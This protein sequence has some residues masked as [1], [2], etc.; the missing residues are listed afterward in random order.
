MKYLVRPLEDNYVCDSIF[1][2]NSLSDAMM[3][4]QRQYL[5]RDIKCVIITQP[6]NV[7]Y[8]SLPKED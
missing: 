7:L 6:E 4:V 3:I 5:E 1:E 8:K 2:T